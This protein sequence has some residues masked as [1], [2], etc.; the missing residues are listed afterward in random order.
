[1][2][3]T[4]SV[5]PR[6]DARGL[7]GA[8]ERGLNRNFPCVASERWA[9]Y[10]ETKHATADNAV[11]PVGL[12]RIQATAHGRSAPNAASPCRSCPIQRRAAMSGVYVDTR[13]AVGGR[14]GSGS[15]M[16]TMPPMS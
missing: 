4:D 3:K 9:G 14:R 15:L 13:A 2:V 16:R 12:D 1:M 8:P 5:V 7:A 10:L 6:L 11:A